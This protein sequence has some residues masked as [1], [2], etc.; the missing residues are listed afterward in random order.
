MGTE[1]SMKAN[2]LFL[3]VPVLLKVG[4][5]VGPAKL[6]VAAGP[7]VGFGL[8][9]KIKAEADG[10]EESE[11]IEWGSDP[12]TDMLKRLDFGAKFGLGAEV[13]NFTF[14]AYYSLVLLIY[15]PIQ[16][17]VQKHRRGLSAFL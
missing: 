13:M 17:L 10:E 6:F 7:Y 9:G 2:L 14:G 12:E 16:N 5:S 8:T 3:D 4:P 11:D 15:H 1:V